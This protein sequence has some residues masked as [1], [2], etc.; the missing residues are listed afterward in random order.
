M[1]ANALAVNISLWC[2]LDTLGLHERIDFAPGRQ[3]MIFDLITRL[4]QQVE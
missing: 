4:L 2:R 3:L 1:P